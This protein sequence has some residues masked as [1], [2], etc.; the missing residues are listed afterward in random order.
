MTET[1][2]EIKDILDH[3]MKTP[4]IAPEEI[5]EA[6]TK[7]KMAYL[8][9]DN[10]EEFLPFIQ[11]YV[12][13]TSESDEY[14]EERVQFLRNEL[15]RF[16]DRIPDM[17]S[18]HHIGGY[19]DP[20]DK[21]ESGNLSKD[22]DDSFEF[23]KPNA[24]NQNLFGPE[25]PENL[26]PTIIKVLE[27]ISTFHDQ[28]V[29]NR[30]ELISKWRLLR[31]AH[32]TEQ[33]K[34][35]VPALLTI[36][37]YLRNKF[38]S[39]YA[40]RNFAKSFHTESISTVEVVKI[41]SNNI[42]EEE[43]FKLR[44][45]LET[46]K[47]SITKNGSI[48][49]VERTTPT[50]STITVGFEKEIQELKQKLKEKDETIR[51]LTEQIQQFSS[52]E[53]ESMTQSADS[54][55]EQLRLFKDQINELE[56]RVI[57]LNH[58]NES[59]DSMLKEQ[60]KNL[61]D[62]R[63]TMEKMHAELKKYKFDSNKTNLNTFGKVRFLNKVLRGFVNQLKTYT[64]YRMMKRTDRMLSS[65]KDVAN[66]MKARMLIQT[67]TLNCGQDTRRSF[68]RWLIK[69]NP[70]LLRETFSKIVITSK[71]SNHVAIWRLKH[72]VFK[73]I[74]TK[75]PE[76][77]KAV[78]RLKAFFALTEMYN[79][80]GMIEKKYF[81]NQLNPNHMSSKEAL[82]HR[83]FVERNKEYLRTVT[84]Q[85]MNTLKEK[86]QVERR[87][88]QRIMDNYTKMQ[89]I[90]FYALK[91][92]T[93]HQNNLQYLLKLL[94][95]SERLQELARRREHDFFNRIKAPKS[96]FIKGVLDRLT[97]KNNFKLA[98][99]MTKLRELVQE[100][101]L[102][103]VQES[104]NEK[105]LDFK[106]NSFI[107]R[108]VNP[109]IN[110]ISQAFTKLR[111]NHRA[112]LIQQL[113]QKQKLAQLF[114]KLGS[115][116][117]A[118]EA[119][120]ISKLIKN[121][122]HHLT[123][124]QRQQ[125]L[126]KRFL[127]NTRNKMR[128]AF[129]TLVDNKKSSEFKLKEHKMR[130]R[131]L[132]S[133][134]AAKTSTK[135]QESLRVMKD[136]LA[137][138]KKAIE[139]QSQKMNR[140][141]LRLVSHHNNL[142]RETLKKL[143]RHSGLAT[144][145]KLMND[146][147]LKTLMNRLL[148]S[149]AR[150]L[151]KSF[152]QLR[153]LAYNSRSK[154]LRQTMLKGALFKKLEVSSHGI[155]RNVL[156]KL[157]LNA[158]NS[159]D[160]LDRTNRL[161]KRLL[162]YLVN[163]YEKQREALQKL[164]HASRI[165][166]KQEEILKGKKR[167]TILRIFFPSQ[168]KAKMAIDALRLQNKMAI[169]NERN[170]SIKQS[171]E[172]NIN[173][174]KKNGL[175]Y[176]LVASMDA[177]LNA[178]LF[179][180]TK[181]SKEK[182]LQEARRRERVFHKLQRFFEGVQAKM[183]C[184]FNKLVQHRVNLKTI[185]DN[186]ATQKLKM[187]QILGSESQAAYDSAKF[188]TL[189][190]QVKNI[191]ATDKVDP[192]FKSIIDE[193]RRINNNG[194]YNE[195]LK[196]IDD[197]SISDIEQLLKFALKHNKDGLYD[198][199]IELINNN[200]H[201]INEII[202]F[203][204]LHNHDGRYS[205]LIEMLQRNP[206]MGKADILDYI[207]KS[208]NPEKYEELRQFIIG[209]KKIDDLIGFMRSNNQDGKYDKPLM[210]LKK[211][212]NP[213]L[214][215]LVQF[216]QL[217][218]DPVYDELRNEINKEDENEPVM[219]VLKFMSNNNSDGRYTDAIEFIKN[220][221][222]AKLSD[223]YSFLQKNNQDGR[224]NEV[225][226]KI[227]EKETSPVEKYISLLEKNN[228]DG[229]FD[230]IIRAFKNKPG[231]SLTEVYEYIVLNNTDGQL[232]RAIALFNE[233]SKYEIYNELIQRN[234]ADGK[235]DD[236][237][238][239]TNSL[240]DPQ[241]TDIIRF[242][243]NNNADGRYEFLLQEINRREDIQ[244]LLKFLKSHQN[245]Q[246][247]EKLIRFI[248]SNP[249]IT[250]IDVADFINADNKDGKYD[251]VLRFI[252]GGEIQTVFDKVVEYMEANNG[253]GKYDEI[254]VQLKTIEKPKL[255]DLYETIIKL[256]GKG[257]YTHLIE[258]INEKPI[259]KVEELLKFA[260][261]N[262]ADGRYSAFIQHIEGL[263][264]PKVSDVIEFIQ[265][266]NSDGKLDD[267]NDLV[268]ES[269]KRTILND[270]L[271]YI[272]NNNQ[273]GK[274]DEILIELRKI[275]KP[276]LIDL[277][278][279]VKSKN[280]NN[281]FEDLLGVINEQEKSEHVDRL[282]Q[283][284]KDHNDS[285]IYTELLE[286][287]KIK[288]NPKISD[289]ITYIQ[290]NN[291]DNRFDKLLEQVNNPNISNEKIMQFMKSNNADGRYDE[292][293]EYLRINPKSKLTDTIQFISSKNGDGKMDEVMTLINRGG[294]C[295]TVG[296]DN[297]ADDLLKFMAK[298]RGKNEYAELFEYLDKN[299]IKDPET[300]LEYLRK[301]NTN[302]RYNE[303]IEKVSQ[304]LT[305]GPVKRNR[306]SNLNLIRPLMAK[307]KICIDKLRAHNK[308]INKK[309]RRGEEI[310]KR[311]LNNVVLQSQMRQA[312]ALAKLT[313]H[314]F[315]Y[316]VSSAHKYQKLA[317][318]MNSL[319]LASLAKKGLVVQ[320][321]KAHSNEV[322]AQQMKRD[323]AWLSLTNKFVHGSQK[324][325]LSSVTTLQQ[326]NKLTTQKLQKMLAR[327]IDGSNGIKNASLR[328]LVDH[329]RFADL[330]KSDIRRTLASLLIHAREKM[331][332]TLI[333][334][335]KHKEM[336]SMKDAK[337]KIKLTKAVNRLKQGN[338]LVLKECLNRLRAHAS[339]VN[340][341]FHHRSEKTRQLTRLMSIKV[342]QS[343]KNYLSALRDHARLSALNEQTTAKLQ[344]R[345]TKLLER[346]SK[347]KVAQAFRRLQENRNQLMFTQV[348]KDT[349]IR[350]L[351][352]KL[353]SA[354]EIR[355]ACSV[356]KLLVN[357]KDKSAQEFSFNSKI[358][359]LMSILSEKRK[360][361]LKTPLATLMTYKNQQTRE[362]MEKIN[363]SK[364]M[365]LITTRLKEVCA[366][367]TY[368]SLSRL[369]SNAHL[370]KNMDR[371][372]MEHLKA[373]LSTLKRKTDAKV[374]R[375]LNHLLKNVEEG[376]VRD[377]KTKEALNT[378]ARI[379]KSSTNQTLS[380]SIN[381]LVKHK[382]RAVG[383][384]MVRDIRLKQLLQRAIDSTR[385][386]QLAV[387]GRLREL[388]NQA[389]KT[390]MK[391]DEKLRKLFSTLVNKNGAC[392]S[393][394]IRVLRN[395]NSE[396]V[397]TTASRNSKLSSVLLKLGRGKVQHCFEKLVVNH[398]KSLLL[399]SNYKRIMSR[400][401]SASQ[402]K[403]IKTLG[404]LHHMSIARK[405]QNQL[406]AALL[407]TI[408]EKMR[409]QR[410][411]SSLLQIKEYVKKQVLDRSNAVKTIKRQVMADV[412]TFY[413]KLKFNNFLYKRNKFNNII[414][415][416]ILGLRK[417]HRVNMRHALDIWS[418]KELKN[419]L[420][421]FSG[422]LN[423]LFQK[424]IS[425]SYEKIKQDYLLKKYRKLINGI[426]NFVNLVEERESSSKKWVMKTMISQ[427]VDNNP[428]FRKVIN[429]MAVCSKPNE[430]IAFWKMRF[431]KN[432]K[433]ES[434]SAEQGLRIKKLNTL[435]KKHIVAQLS[436][437]Y[438]KIGNASVKIDLGVSLMSR[439]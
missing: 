389:Q 244:A 175:L 123:A 100:R 124:Q 433:A 308:A 61:L 437:G 32:K 240:A 371:D 383:A 335:K 133:S 86:V 253:D 265:K 401:Q 212:D 223:V 188:S 72:L 200:R 10:R 385:G 228:E 364:A 93:R 387:L 337:D 34:A 384:A 254:L 350:R 44:N 58:E 406:K 329:K 68:L 181:Y 190:K 151:S 163:V 394:V 169:M 404:K 74:H 120:V 66:R 340:S 336:M 26:K 229:A 85:A 318:L 231:V 313:K 391:K 256:N 11:N 132:F 83:V 315:E 305:Y 154:Q 399:R 249:A 125:K 144:R 327:L 39:F 314:R 363:M 209:N 259:S 116:T 107:Q 38:N 392:S 405:L 14:I 258:M 348:S 186:Y 214:T 91:I 302:G 138:S 135:E 196:K 430:Q 321:L 294:S 79:Y 424:R 189:I 106:K 140:F 427:F 378:F 429:I 333:M 261:H 194:K 271:E 360:D 416:L 247:F 118:M 408:I 245:A 332:K 338:A 242:I 49:R 204:R 192:F 241:L 145:N 208:K 129:T 119:Q 159:Q 374:S 75:L 323:K 128:I 84:K 380:T 349:R 96:D 92:K 421:K 425:H 428:W 165:I 434:L 131:Q 73:P 330:R 264:N 298:S 20:N 121:R 213:Q 174:R 238:Q 70:D 112:G 285:G 390:Q 272:A 167:M 215:D 18:L 262:N 43:I 99:A 267:L 250:M 55:K 274:Y 269:E 221:K 160:R 64:F 60:Y 369:Q 23:L 344:N 326:H 282:V 281:K 280:I 299:Y 134:L 87:V 67:R 319:K 370:S 372:K 176:L 195:L 177:K 275:E 115:A 98:K 225:I 417:N 278:T 191:I 65:L 286:I 320:G 423:G 193:V 170:H 113:G 303:L 198:P 296:A 367:N 104:F 47:N 257:E 362:L 251:D 101:R 311:I 3:V 201:Q 205:E 347:N 216:L 288:K 4:F 243:K 155:A 76:A 407:T 381:E 366:L 166:S 57:A 187:K 403:S 62:T 46:Y 414:S 130:Q 28:K 246:E 88:L 317:K 141:L 432:L 89:E 50:S 103:S 230:S 158:L 54:H 415:S 143:E 171:Y 359:R 53:F 114:S 255:S 126:L 199:V 17:F 358:S 373:L 180:L 227:N 388:Y 342:D 9:L 273:D 284:M 301:N 27:K 211:M 52:K 418:R 233:P 197:R 361:A 147:K 78:R 136:C 7:F 312:G 81:I 217:N 117:A 12:Q 263:N 300:L 25:I 41:Q 63:S 24:L 426:M 203:A 382:T 152:E 146:S 365:Q 156:N 164:I 431:S 413:R 69:S 439:Q 419:K 183:G 334:L 219:K 237:I 111:E 235:M 248:E 324:K 436:H 220:S 353:L 109:K 226:D 268:N 410:R 150:K 42:L 137:Q 291:K 309:R 304:L 2:I 202:R 5:D 279:I 341:Q 397:R 297:E 325:L 173:K 22:I 6:V 283:F 346:G 277:V 386:K 30:I 232:N 236:L 161:K 395:N 207:A 289:I 345:F 185:D 122:D 157:K 21:E 287:I 306:S 239:F 33:L 438:W 149:N 110:K 393:Q 77:V 182:R 328:A 355:M 179:K 375:T 435:L 376:R 316:S 379:A 15:D 71:I 105:M 162:G 218:S 398:F 29:A 276:T 184:A 108:L 322:N 224:F 90:G 292:A 377:A 153:S 16:Y 168:W 80:K 178:A 210:Y 351:I 35:Q 1:L 56:S 400:I 295:E 95:G 102:R 396:V 290:A 402:L 422:L 270:A 357:S 412:A 172:N 127:E 94:Q 354:Q 8:T 45:E 420:L 343:L 59:K 19:K 139:S 40:L 48:I 36:Q 142:R 51:S 339:G 222:A 148:N 37:K 82:L 356:D 13:E 234:N 411:S 97:T 331:M 260:K 352:S 368:T 252:N 409:S 206:S 31:L 310:L 266:N 293:I 307:M